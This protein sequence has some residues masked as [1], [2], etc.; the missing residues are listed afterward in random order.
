MIIPIINFCENHLVHFYS[1]PN[2]HNYL[3]NRMYFNMLGSVP[4]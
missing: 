2:V 1:V 4:S 3:Q